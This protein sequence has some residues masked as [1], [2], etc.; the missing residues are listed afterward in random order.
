VL[1]WGGKLLDAG[2]EL[3]GDLWD[4]LKDAIPKIYSWITDTAGPQ[5][6]STV[7]GIGAALYDAGVAVINELWNGLKAKWAEVVQWF[8][9]RLDWLRRQWPLSSEPKDPSSPLHGFW[10]AGYNLVQEIIRGMD[11]ALPDLTD[12]L[13]ELLGNMFKLASGFSTFGS[14]IARKFER[15]TLDPIRDAIDKIDDELDSLRTDFKLPGAARGREEELFRLFKIDPEQA[16]RILRDELGLDPFQLRDALLVFETMERNEK[17]RTRLA[18]ERLALEKELV[19]QQKK[20]LELQEK[21]QQLQFLQEQFKLLELIKEFGLNP[22]DILGGLTLGLDASID[23][24]LDAMLRAIDEIVR[25]ANEKLGV[26][27]P[28]KVFKKI[29]Q[30]T[31]A[32]FMA[33]IESM[34]PM[35]SQALANGLIP[36]QAVAA[37]AVAS[38]ARAVNNS[39]SV[40]FGNVNISNGMELAQF[41]TRVRRIVQND[42][43]R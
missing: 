2:L 7:K 34:E 17:E 32:G 40:N 42:M 30:N 3:I 29:G 21:Q 11:M 20:L 26:S 18:E 39:T 33:G 37:P 36:A 14:F 28:S 25:K 22:E 38:G 1:D 6:V 27:S 15:E 23:D 8:Q 16:K 4:G 13:Q 12:K 41:E 19:E 5:I 10:K 24:L 31:M 35:V 9:D 43:R